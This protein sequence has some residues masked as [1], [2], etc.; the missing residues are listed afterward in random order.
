[1][2]DYAPCKGCTDRKIGC[3]S[4]CTKYMKFKVANEVEKRR[5]EKIRKENDWHKIIGGYTREEYLNMTKG[6]RRK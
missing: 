2:N 5:I 4:K 3:H 6:R 1:M